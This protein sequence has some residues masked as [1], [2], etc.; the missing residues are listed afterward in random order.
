[1][2]EFVTFH[3]LVRFSESDV[4]L[5]N[6]PGLRSLNKFGDIQKSYKM[7]SKSQ[8]FRATQKIAQYF[9]QIFYLKKYKQENFSSTF[10]TAR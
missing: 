4:R 8:I 10:K 6:L 1:M 7:S 3:V 9:A 2:S 5:L